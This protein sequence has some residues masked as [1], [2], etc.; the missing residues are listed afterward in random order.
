M[1]FPSHSILRCRYFLYLFQ[2]PIRHCESARDPHSPSQLGTERAFGF[3]KERLSVEE[4]FVAQH[5]HF[6]GLRVLDTWAAFVVSVELLVAYFLGGVIPL[7]IVFTSGWMCQTITLWF[8]VANHPLIRGDA[9]PQLNKSGLKYCTASDSQADLEPTMYLPFYLL[10][11][12]VPIYSWLAMEDAHE[13]HHDNAQLAK[14]SKFDVAYW[15]FIKPL[16]LM[17]L[18]WNVVVK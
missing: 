16:E 7:F 3:F 5:I 10:D 15:T 17:G 11:A 14:R 12:L 18:V 9:Q 1:L 6:T 2:I 4:E 13:H 8:N